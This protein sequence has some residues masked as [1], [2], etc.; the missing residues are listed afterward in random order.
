MRIDLENLPSDTVLLHGLVRDMAA[1]VESRDGEIERL[2]LI[3]K[4][5]QRAQFGRRSERVDGDQLALGLEDLETDL[6]QAE[7]PQR[8]LEPPD[9][10]TDKKPRRKPLPEHLP[11]EEVLLD[12]G[13]ASC[14]CCGG[15]LHQV[16]E[17]VSE[18]LDWVQ[19]RLREERGGVTAGLPA[20][21]TWPWPEPP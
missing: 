9:E 4:K 10:D 21:G 5:L 8:A 2:Q 18:M 15:A 19:L 16:G 6:A 11:R 17:S 14:P 1:V 13:A 12:I 3:I 7:T 20:I